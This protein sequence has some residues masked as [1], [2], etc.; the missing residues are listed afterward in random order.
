M[1]KETQ[2]TRRVDIQSNCYRGDYMRAVVDKTIGEIHDDIVTVFGPYARDAYIVKDNNPYYT[3]DG[4]E[5]IHSMMFDNELSQYVLT[6]LYQAIYHQGKT[7]GDGTTTLAVF[8]TN[9]YNILR[10]C[11]D[12]RDKGDVILHT[13]RAD[14]NDAIKILNERIKKLAV[15]LTD[16]DLKAMFFTCMQEESLTHKL[17]DQLHEAIMDQAYIVVNPSDH[18][19]EFKITQHSD[20]IIKCTKQFSI[21]PFDETGK[22][23]DYCSILYCN[24]VLDITDPDLVLALATREVRFSDTPSTISDPVPV[25]YIILCNGVN[26][27]TRE[28]LKQVNSKIRDYVTSTTADIINTFNNVVI[29]TINDY[30]GMDRDSIEDLACTITDEEELGT[31][32]NPLSFE[33]VLYQAFCLSKNENLLRFDTDPAVIDKMKNLASTFFAIQY[34]GQEGMRL[35]KELGPVA[36]ARYNKLKEEIENEPSAVRKV[37]LNRRLRR[38]YG[39]F[40]ELEIGAKLIKDSQRKYELIVDAVVS[41]A[42]A[43]RDGVIHGNSIIAAYKVAN[44]LIEEYQKSSPILTAGN[45]AYIDDPKVAVWFY[46]AC[47]L[48]KTLDDMIRNR[49]FSKLGYESI[50]GGYYNIEFMKRIAT[51]DPD[52][53]DLNDPNENNIFGDV[54]PRIVPTRTYKDEGGNE[55]T[56]NI[57]IVE[58]VNIITTIIENSPVVFELATARTFHL[59][60][61]I[62]NYI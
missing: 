3:R 58:P 42:E 45:D 48:L 18:P 51:V 35:L 38:M 11:Y 24:G 2:T 14:W 27:H 13:T 43:V 29:M 6:M 60:N 57:N 37:A 30:R 28:T 12:N 52:K 15:P 16:D 36:Q 9:L 23:I 5:V 34:D 53:F 54:E 26:E 10:E 46:I 44:E 39:R 7:V 25:T 31:L 50:Y 8:Y 33:S 4:L 21:K 22:V 17:Y 49:E 55:D 62:G 59:K 41:S 40:I 47:A 1:P 61:Y 20:P 19:D 32:V 56:F